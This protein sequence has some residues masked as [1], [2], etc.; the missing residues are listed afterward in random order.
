M[1]EM[2]SAD[3][4]TARPTPAS[5][6][7]AQTGE[8]DAA[9]TFAQLLGQAGAAKP[10]DTTA[11]A[12]A[13]TPEEDLDV[14]TLENGD[15]APDDVLDALAEALEALAAQLAGTTDTTAQEDA[16]PATE[17]TTLD[18]A[19]G[20]LTDLLEDFDA[21]YGTNTLEVLTTNAAAL[22]GL[23][24][25]GE[26]GNATSEFL[27]MAS[28]LLGVGTK[29]SLQDQPVAA[30]P[31]STPQL[32]DLETANDMAADV[33]MPV[34]ETLGTKPET[35]TKTVSTDTGTTSTTQLQPQADARTPV[36]FQ[37]LLQARPA[38]VSDTAQP[39][40]AQ[41]NQSQSSGFASNLTSQIKSAQLN[42]GTTRI[43]L[44]PRGLGGIEIDIARNAS[45]DMQVTIR[46]ENTSV[47]SAL[48]E[49]REMLL[50]ML[51]QN[52]T[53]VGSA[54]LE[55]ESF[56]Q[57]GSRQQTAERGDLQVSSANDDEDDLIAET[58]SAST[59]TTADGGVD[60]LT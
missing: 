10:V 37:D 28:D 19:A 47:L 25:T 27:G 30:A 15:P 9:S 38:H 8:D 18:G 22:P 29:T 16:A 34:E 12:P 41:Q 11:K 32:F 42:E 53:T 35:T 40:A 54:N 50:N 23:V 45:G 26:T 17:T 1:I 46:A 60:I 39:Q 31:Q 55:F 48:R 56:G 49:N 14:I 52:G 58:L 13:Q 6:N 59:T 4:A 20:Q 5:S 57:D 2:I 21:T 51:H 36:A 7:G 3:T 43:E 33:D 44:A 24:V